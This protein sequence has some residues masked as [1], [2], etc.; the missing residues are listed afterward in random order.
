[1]WNKTIHILL[2]TILLVFGSKSIAAATPVFHGEYMTIA[3]VSHHIDVDTH[4]TKLSLFQPSAIE[5]IAEIVEETIEEESQTEHLSAKVAVS[6]AI[7]A[8]YLEATGSFKS[9]YHYFYDAAPLAA[10]N[11]L[12]LLYQ[13]FRL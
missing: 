5:M 7:Y 8:S 6:H 12:Y 2:L 1:M 4:Q 11:S 9:P 13:V 10:S 3:V